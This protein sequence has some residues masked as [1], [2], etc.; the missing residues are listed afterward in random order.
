[1]RETR[2]SQMPAVWIRAYTVINAYSRCVSKRG[3]F[4]YQTKPVSWSL[5]LL[6][7]RLTVVA[8]MATIKAS[9]SLSNWRPV[10]LYKYGCFPLLLTFAMSG[11]SYTVETALHFG[12]CIR[13]GLSHQLH[14]VWTDHGVISDWPCRKGVLFL[15]PLSFQRTESF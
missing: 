8:A 7:S 3:V 2:D 10:P 9:F 4:W 13:W 15:S 1:M 6:F 5:V 14:C 11:H 12:V